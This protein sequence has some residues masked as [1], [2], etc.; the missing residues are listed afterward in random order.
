MTPVMKKLM[1]CKETLTLP[2]NVVKMVAVHG[3]LNKL[4]WIWDNGVDFQKNIME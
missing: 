4:F 2:F 3:Y 1:I